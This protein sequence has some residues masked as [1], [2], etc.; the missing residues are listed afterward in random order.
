I[1][2]V[3]GVFDR[4]R[5]LLTVGT[6]C[7]YLKK[8]NRTLTADRWCFRA[9]QQG[10]L[11]VNTLQLLQGLANAFPDPTGAGDLFPL[12]L[13]RMCR[14]DQD[15]VIFEPF[16]SLQEGLS[17][18]DEN[19][20]EIENFLPAAIDSLTLLLKN[21]APALAPN[22]LLVKRM[23]EDGTKV[24]DHLTPGVVQL[25]PKA[26][27]AIPLPANFAVLVSQDMLNNIFCGPFLRF[28]EAQGTLAPAP[29]EEHQVFD[30]LKKFDA[31]EAYLSFLSEAASE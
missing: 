30:F 7:L 8:G 25:D 10:V 2:V 29:V 26:V 4:I 31:H 23:L 16:L 5:H 24:F 18:L 14:Q 19:P 6:V 9:I 12:V 17:L 1:A 15:E 21:L 13:S 11:S 22:R 3:R 28:D 20:G 27:P